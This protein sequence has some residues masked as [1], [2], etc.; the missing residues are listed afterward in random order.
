MKY[1]DL[2]INQRIAAKGLIQTDP[3]LAIF[4]AV[5]LLWDF[6]EAVNQLL[7]KITEPDYH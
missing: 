3:E 1:E 6:R 7:N 2:N 5:W 4:K